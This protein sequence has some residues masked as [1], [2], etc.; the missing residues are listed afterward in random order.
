MWRFWR[1]PKPPTH[2]RTAMAILTRAVDKQAPDWTEI[3]IVRR[4]DRPEGGVDMQ[5]LK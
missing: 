2:Y 3:R 1:W 5:I 4:R